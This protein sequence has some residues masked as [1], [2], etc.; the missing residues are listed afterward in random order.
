MK[1]TKLFSDDFPEWPKPPFNWW[2]GFMFVGLL[3]CWKFFESVGDETITQFRETFDKPHAIA[4]FVPYGL[5]FLILTILTN[6]L[7]A[8]LCYVCLHAGRNFLWPRG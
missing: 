4:T 3:I 1:T 8:L 6:S 5:L 2:A 7:A